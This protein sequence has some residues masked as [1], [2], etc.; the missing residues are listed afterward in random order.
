M[1]KYWSIFTYT[2]TLKINSLREQYLIC[3]A[4]VSAVMFFI[5]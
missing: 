4:L 2:D 3:G 1:Q 5:D